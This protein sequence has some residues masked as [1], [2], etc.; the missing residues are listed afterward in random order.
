MIY[1]NRAELP[2][3]MFLALTANEYDKGKSDISATGLLKSPRQ[4][5][6]ALRHDSEIVVDASEMLWSV[7]GT[8]VHDLILKHSKH[9]NGL[10]EERFYAKVK[11]PVGEWVVSGECDL[12]DGI[13]KGVYRLTDYKVAGVFSYLLER[14]NGGVKAD[15]EAQLNI[16]RWLIWK[17]LGWDVGLLRIG[18][19]IRDHMASKVGV[20]DGYP[21]IPI[22]YL[23]AKAWPIEQIDKF[24]AARVALH[25][26]AEQ[27]EDEALPACTQEERWERGEKWAVMKRGKARAEKLC[28]SRAEA[29]AFAKDV[30]GG[31]VVHRPGKSVKCVP[32]Y[33]HGAFWC[34]LWQQRQGAKD[35]GLVTA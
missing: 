2:E 26:E 19:I 22:L 27:M 35:N 1:T 8:A 13:G 3:P 24:I 20:E 29:D 16:Y 30:P 10:A 25:Q 5:L 11:G 31:S 12:I 34:N 7:L 6:L 18:L 32:Q 28:D 33:C 9:V 17:N 14:K 15:W 4:R 23:D 21:A